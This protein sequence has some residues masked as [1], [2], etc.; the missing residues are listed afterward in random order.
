LPGVLIPDKRKMHIEEHPPPWRAIAKK[1]RAAA[2][3]KIPPSWRLPP[4]TVSAISSRSSPAVLD[5][6]KTCGLFTEAEIDLTE[7]YDAVALL[8]L[9][10]KGD[11]TSY[12]ATQ[13]CCK[14]AAIAQQLVYYLH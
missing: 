10:A 1:Y 2:A 6:P 13:A 9:L 14:T 5:V 11:I 3:A 12:A 4:R 7:N 8:E